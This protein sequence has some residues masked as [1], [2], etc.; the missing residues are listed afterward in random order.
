[1]DEGEEARLTPDGPTAAV[2]DSRGALPFRVRSEA[3]GVHN[4]PEFPGSCVVVGGLRF[5]VVA[6]QGLENGF[7][8]LLDPWPADAVIRGML[9]YGPP[10]VRAAQRERQDAFD[11]ERAARWSFL[12][13]PFVGLLPE[14]RQLL[15]CDRLSLDPQLTTFAGVLLELATAMAAAVSVKAGAASMLIGEG[16]GIF[17]VTPALLRLLGLVLMKETA[18]AWWLNAVFE[19]AASLASSS[20]ARADA[21]VLPLT[22]DAFWSRL[23]RP[24]RQQRGEDG[25]VVVSGL[26]PHLSWSPTA[27]TRMGGVLPSLRVGSDYWSVAALPAS[28]DNGRL[29]Y[30]YHLWPRRD[31]N[32]LAGLPDPAPPDV[33]QYQNEVLED[34]AR[35]WD[36]IFGAAPWLPS[37][38]PRGAQERAYRGRG[39]APA[40]QRWAVLTAL[41]LSV[42]GAWMLFGRDPF[43]VLTG[44]VLLAESSYRVWR[45]LSGDYAPSL[46]GLGLSD[47]LVPERKTYQEHLQAER[48]TLLEKSRA[49][50]AP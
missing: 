40:A 41:A 46:L 22:R 45:T 7:R 21:T 15:A 23:A 48:S 28:I 38:L 4:R 13:A 16:F 32:M 1:V 31:E 5:E 14:Q 8:Y 43:S 12:V 24:D 10:L 2:I 50:S 20:T 49:P 25:S 39:G 18:G 30:A 29:Q 6:E 36:E 34:V 9:S 37:L 3:V 19:A 35:Q 27:A 42:V 47:Y 11:R 33:R 17:I 44:L 26:L